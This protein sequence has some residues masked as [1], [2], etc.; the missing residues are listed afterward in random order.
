MK[1]IATINFLDHFIFY[2]VSVILP[3]YLAYKNFSLSEIGILLSVMP[4]VSMFFRILFAYVAD[5]IGYRIFFIADGVAATLM[6]AIY[7]FAV[8]PLHFA[9]AKVSE[10]VSTQSFWAVNRTA[11]YS[12]SNKN[13]EKD[14]VFMD[15]VRRVAIASG[16]FLSGFLIASISFG[17]TFIFLAFV[18]LA[19]AVVAYTLEER[20]EHKKINLKNLPRAVFKKRKPTFWLTALAMVF[21]VSL[22]T[23]LIM[24][25]FPIFMV[26]QLQF[27]YQEIGLFLTIF[28]MLSALA[29][30]ITSLK[31]NMF[32]R[33]LFLMCVLSISLVLIPM[34][35]GGLF[36]L[37]FFLFSFSFGVL[38]A[39][40]EFII[41][42]ETKNSDMVSTDIGV[43]HI[44]TRI[45]Q[46]LVLVGGGFLAQTF[47]FFPVFLISFLMF[48]AFAI[49]VYKLIR[50][51]Q[52]RT[53]STRN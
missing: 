40:H 33:M 19:L 41:A 13:E 32:E 10:A 44:P 22:L 34:S 43:L 49:V 52:L 16:T 30:Y 15:V 28:Y 38:F 17:N 39:F 6:N 24:F 20:N 5:H 46:T 25:V 3:L 26:G 51:K 2:S 27:S 4:F 18:S 23:L 37:L 8:A 29:S 14:A 31:I 47:G 48:I 42:K 45:A 9:V 35:S 50:S 1:K 36:V 53:R 7:C 21:S 11:I 12:S